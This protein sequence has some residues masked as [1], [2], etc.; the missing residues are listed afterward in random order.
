MFTITFN[1]VIISSV[2]TE[3][4]AIGLALSLHKSSNV[5][6]NIVVTKNDVIMLSIFIDVS[7]ASV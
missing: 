5:P 7:D 2:D 4:M 3:E 1:N 6:H